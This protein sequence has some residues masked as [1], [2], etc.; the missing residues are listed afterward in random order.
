VLDRLGR[1]GRATGALARA[2]APPRIQAAGGVDTTVLPASAGGSSVGA[3]LGVLVGTGVSGGMGVA[4]PL[5]LAL[6]ALGAGAGALGRRR[7]SAGR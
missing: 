7:R 3:L 5:I 4:L 6:I 1:A 2:G